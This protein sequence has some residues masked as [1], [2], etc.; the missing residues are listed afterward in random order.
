MERHDIIPYPFL[1]HFFQPFMLNGIPFLQKT[2]ENSNDTQVRVIQTCQN[3]QMSHHYVSQTVL[4]MVFHRFLSVFG[5]F[6]IVQ[7]PVKTR[8]K[9]CRTSLKTL[10]KRFKAV[11]VLF[12]SKFASWWP[13][14]AL[15]HPTPPK[16]SPTTQ[17]FQL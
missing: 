17:F 5:S 6:E 2:A 8:L 4:F 7:V 1:P 14:C 16:Y 15:I 10:P 13:V 3:I 11:F 9:V 12:P